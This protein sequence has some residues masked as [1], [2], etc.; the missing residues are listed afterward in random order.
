VPEVSRDAVRSLNRTA[1]GT[2][3]LTGRQLDELLLSSF[4]L[5]PDYSGLLL[6]SD[7]ALRRL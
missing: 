2:A 1:G 7:S 5:S 3:W 4:T 6:L